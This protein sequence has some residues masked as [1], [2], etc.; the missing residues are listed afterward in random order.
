MTAILANI[1]VLELNPAAMALGFVLAAG[2]SVSPYLGWLLAWPALLVLSA[3]MG[4][5]DFFGRWAW[6]WQGDFDIYFLVGYY[7]IIGS[8]F[9]FWR[10]YGG[11]KNQ[12]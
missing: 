9:Y 1:L 7:L 11:R 6:L 8:G 5:I 10:I 2:A 3:M 4:I 12:G